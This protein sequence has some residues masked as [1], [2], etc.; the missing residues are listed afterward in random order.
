MSTDATL[1]KSSV[2]SSEMPRNE[3]EVNSYR[4]LL[5]LQN[6]PPQCLLIVSTSP[7]GTCSTSPALTC[8]LH[9]RTRQLPGAGAQGR[10]SGC[11][12]SRHFTT[13]FSGKCPASLTL[14]WMLSS[15]GP[16]P[17]PQAWG[18]RELPNVPLG[19][20]ALSQLRS[21]SPPTGPHTSLSLQDPPR[22][23]E[24]GPAGLQE[25]ELFVRAT[26]GHPTGA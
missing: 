19:R 18:L 25:A 15:P 21:S 20:E 17:T 23:W 12:L 26:P 14:P 1:N 13:A 24:P 6:L 10:H 22:C 7:S 11:C 5:G 4:G 2:E 9:G 3:P 16:A 8:L